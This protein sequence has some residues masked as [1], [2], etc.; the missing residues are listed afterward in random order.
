M[1]HDTQNVQMSSRLSLVTSMQIT[2]IMAFQGLPTVGERLR[3]EPYFH[4]SLKVQT[5]H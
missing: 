4:R 5:T 2:M 1:R 3:S